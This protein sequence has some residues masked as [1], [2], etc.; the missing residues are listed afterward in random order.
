M[1]ES[2]L[3]FGELFDVC[4]NASTTVH[5][6]RDR[7]GQSKP[8]PIICQCDSVCLIYGD[9]CLDYEFTC[10]DTLSPSQSELSDPLRGIGT[11]GDTE[12]IEAPPRPTSPLVTSSARPSIF[13]NFD[14]VARQRESLIEF[15]KCIRTSEKD[16]FILIS[17]C[18][19]RSYVGTYV[20]QRCSDIDSADVISILPVV[21]RNGA[22][23]RNV[24][25]AF[26]SGETYES[27]QFWSL[28]LFCDNEV[29]SYS[30]ANVQ[31]DMF[32]YLRH[33]LSICLY[34]SK[35]HDLNST[36][37]RPC[38]SHGHYVCNSSKSDEKA[39]RLCDAYSSP[40]NVRGRWY[41]NAHCALCTDGFV[42]YSSVSCEGY[43]LN[44]ESSSHKGNPLS[45]LF[46]FS[47]ADG[48][49]MIFVD[50]SQAM[51]ATPNCSTTQWFDPFA[52]GCRSL[53]CPKYYIA[54]DGACVR[55]HNDSAAMID[56]CT[57]HIWD[58]SKAGSSGN[59]AFDVRLK[60]WV[61]VKIES[62]LE[63]AHEVIKEAFRQEFLEFDVRIVDT[64][65]ELFKS[66]ENITTSNP[67]VVVNLRMESNTSS[68]FSS[69]FVRRAARLI[70]YTGDASIRLQT[71][72]LKN[73]PT[74]S[75]L[76]E[77]CSIVRGKL[78][79][80]EVWSDDVTRFTDKQFKDMV[81]FDS[82]FNNIPVTFVLSYD[83]QEYG[84]QVKMYIQCCSKVLT[85][86][87]VT[88]NV[89]EFDRL[90]D[91]NDS[92]VHIKSGTVVTPEW[93]TLIGD[94]MIGVCEFLLREH[95][96][97]RRD[98]TGELDSQSFIT[99]FGSVCSLVLL[100][101]AIIT[102]LIYRD[103]WT[104]PGK[105]FICLNISMFVAHLTLILDQGHISE[106]LC[107][108]V[109]V[110][111]HYSWL[112]VF[113][114]SNALAVDLTRTF[115]AKSVRMVYRIKG[116]VQFVR[117]CVY[118]WGVA[119]TIVVASIAAHFKLVVGGV[120]SVHRTCWLHQGKSVILLFAVPVGLL[121]VVNTLLLIVIICGIT[122]RKETVSSASGQQN[123]AFL[124]TILFFKLFF[125]LGIT[126]FLGFVASMLQSELVWY[127]FNVVN[128]F[129][130]AGVA[131][132]L[133]CSKQLYSKLMKKAT[134][135]KRVVAKGSYCVLVWEK[136]SDVSGGIHDNKT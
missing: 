125:C 79:S 131:S 37:P 33:L 52:G 10:P 38:V 64:Y 56:E 118:S 28:H 113:L 2:D 73:Y 17:Q 18:V 36:Y 102:Y 135:H 88:L 25:C 19:D 95:I 100:S 42:N 110:S 70:Q 101:F 106:Q 104:L 60:S 117:Y 136:V 98:S 121:L 14:V 13:H 74:L 7:C 84:E 82:T 54:K 91:D 34:D 61:T 39:S 66:L 112:S 63:N 65:R 76:R 111:L 22:N 6:C 124:S 44:F 43:F 1:A 58:D 133:L 30:G 69:I 47:A 116:N 78:F 9:C 109:G 129:S 75:S 108:V 26:C 92:L 128:S 132:C 97:H 11:S 114:W 93:Y 83:L 67:T 5:S 59:N 46:N 55:V 27:L 31:G 90:G 127:I 96:L 120:Y 126:W 32:S 48:G 81:H 77:D 85:C 3:S 123:S 115:H 105:I 50:Q 89:S 4:F 57:H 51:Q 23:Y 20:E 87:F 86:Q 12:S 80:R 62:A 29:A 134:E 72:E 53:I 24:Y 71:I 49:R 35:P 68:R 94:G 8:F 99:L 41:K 119:A 107:L 130:G 21:V 122:K 45:M 40:T 16:H 103:L 15:T